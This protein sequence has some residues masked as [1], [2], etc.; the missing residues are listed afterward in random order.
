MKLKKGLYHSQ[1]DQR[2]EETK[3]KDLEPLERILWKDHT[4]THL[5][6]SNEGPM[7]MGTNALIDPDTMMVPQVDPMAANSAWIAATRP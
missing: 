3:K 7:I 1:I 5:A 2:I 6:A 4:S